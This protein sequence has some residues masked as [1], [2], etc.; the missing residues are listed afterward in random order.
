VYRY[1]HEVT[2]MGKG[3]SERRPRCQ[4]AKVVVLRAGEGSA[5]PLLSASGEGLCEAIE[6]AL[7]GRAHGIMVR[8]SDDVL[9]RLDMLVEGGICESRAGAAAFMI[10]EGMEANE[11]LFRRV[12]DT[13]RRIAELKAELHSLVGPRSTEEEPA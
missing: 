10:R 13:T 1:P 2:I 6:H 4:S 8:V 5:E 7:E 3:D 9:R 12:E 11:G